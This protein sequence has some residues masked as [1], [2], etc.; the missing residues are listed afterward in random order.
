MC[1]L[2]KINFRIF[3]NALYFDGGHLNSWMDCTADCVVACRYTNDSNYSESRDNEE[4]SNEC[5][6]CGETVLGAENQ[7]REGVGQ[8]L[9]H[10]SN[11][12]GPN[13]EPGRVLGRSR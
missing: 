3:N 13:E 1:V 10:V 11:K 8:G 5:N 2:N 7:R 4:P 6:T 12:Y 9:L